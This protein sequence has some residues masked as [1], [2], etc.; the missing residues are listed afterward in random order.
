MLCKKYG[1][2]F[3]VTGA[4]DLLYWDVVHPS[5]KLPPSDKPKPHSRR[6]KIGLP[7]KKSGRR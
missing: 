3:Y 5:G 4:I 6:Q 7:P 2:W 1:R